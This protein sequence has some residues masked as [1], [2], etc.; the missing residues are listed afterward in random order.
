MIGQKEFL[1]IIDLLE[2]NYDK[3][4]NEKII[5]IWYDEFKDYDKEVFYKCVVETIKNETFFPTI[6]KIKE[7]KDKFTEYVDENGFLH[8]NGRRML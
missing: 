5:K 8:K 1:E 4:L 6:N 7:F 3:K 2:V